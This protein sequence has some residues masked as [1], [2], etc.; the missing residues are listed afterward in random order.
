MKICVTGQSSTLSQP[1]SQDGLT[2]IIPTPTDSISASGTSCP[3]T[4]IVTDGDNEEVDVSYNA[5]TGEITLPD[6]ATYKYKW[7]IEGYYLNTSE[8]GTILGCDQATFDTTEPLV[9]ISDLMAVIATLADSLPDAKC[10][11]CQKQCRGS[12]QSQ[13]SSHNVKT[14]EQLTHRLHR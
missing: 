3:K 13:T 10:A 7:Y 12:F 4:L 9:E 8:E 5:A 2:V 14:P 11:K 6:H 1:Y